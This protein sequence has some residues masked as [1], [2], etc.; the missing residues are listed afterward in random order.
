MS[1][2]IQR[3]LWAG[4]VVASIGL[5]V[6]TLRLVRYSRGLVAA[7]TTSSYGL[8]YMSDRDGMY[9]LYTCGA[10][11]ENDR[12]SPGS[13]DGDVLPA[14]QTG[15]AEADSSGSVA[16][17]R[18]TDPNRSATD[19]GM[20]GTVCVLGD[21]RREAITVS[22]FITR[23]LTVRPAWSPDGEHIAFAA[24]EDSNGDGKFT[25]EEAGLYIG[26]LDGR[27]PVRLASGPADD[28]T[29]SWSPDGGMLLFQT[30]TAGRPWPTARLLDLS[31]GSVVSHNEQTTLACWSPDGQHI[32]A[33][34]MIDRSIDVLSA[35]DGTVEFSVNGPE[36]DWQSTLIYLAWLP[37]E[38]TSG[39]WLAQVSATAQES[40][41]VFYVRPADSE[42]TSVWRPLEQNARS[43]LYPAV[44]PDGKWITYSIFDPATDQLS[45]V[46]LPPDGKPVTLFADGSFSGF[47]CW[48][49]LPVRSGR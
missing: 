45:L 34:N 40:S 11:G 6:A 30:R 32:A 46:V 49:S 31:D 47:G 41:G 21:G 44:S 35:I 29:L 20:W 7:P 3:W 33:Y 25:A 43:A 36:G 38:G 12:P 42:S 16:F 27:P 24:V 9:R 22:G 4:V 15:V 10:L 37:V 1:E 28:T 26:T 18:I 8:V 14:C 39:R 48:Q 17:L 2:R 13:V 5:T 19:V 23:V